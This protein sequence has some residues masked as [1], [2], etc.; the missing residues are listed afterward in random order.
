MGNWLKKRKRARKIKEKGG[1]MGYLG[2]AVEI[3][4]KVKGERSL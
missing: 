3:E 2:S 4:R 1:V